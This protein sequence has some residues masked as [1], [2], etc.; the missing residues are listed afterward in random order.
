MKAF[1]LIT[2][3]VVAF[4]AAPAFAAGTKMM[5]SSAVVPPMTAEMK[6]PASQP[7]GCPHN[8]PM[9]GGLVQTQDGRLIRPPRMQQD[10]AEAPVT[11]DLNRTMGIQEASR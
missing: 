6:P 3:A 7:G 10:A 2:A 9:C 4:S 1:L 11:S 8:Q 5:R